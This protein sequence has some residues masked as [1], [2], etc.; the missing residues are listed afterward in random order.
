MEKTMNNTAY[1]NRKPPIINGFQNIL[2][3]KLGIDLHSGDDEIFEVIDQLQN[4]NEELR[5]YAIHKMNCNLFMIGGL[6][7]NCGLDKLLNKKN[8]E[9]IK[10]GGK[11]E[12]EDDTPQYG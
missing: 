3:K 8:D 9:W 5:K 1:N 7:C 4:Q 11:A 2:C 12:K 10:E 6:D